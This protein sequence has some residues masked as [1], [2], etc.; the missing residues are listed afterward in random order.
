[1]LIITT[2]SDEIKAWEMNLIRSYL[3]K[4]KMEIG[5]YK[6][7]SRWDGT[8]ANLI[9]CLGEKALKR[10]SSEN[11]EDVKNTVLLASVSEFSG[12]ILSTFGFDRVAVD[13][14]LNHAVMMA[15]I[16]AKNNC[17]YPE[18][19]LPR[20]NIWEPTFQN[21]FAFMESIKDSVCFDL[22]TTISS[23][24]HITH[25]GLATSPLDS[26]SIPLYSGTH[27]RFNE[28]EELAL[29]Q[30]FSEILENENITKINHNLC[31]D[32]SVMLKH[33]VVTKGK[34]FDTMFAMHTCYADLAK[35]DKKKG[36][37][38]KSGKKDLGFCCAL[39]CDVP[40]W[41][42]TS[43][44]NMTYYNALDCCN[45]YALYLSLQRELISLGAE[46]TFLKKCSE[47]E[48][49]IYLSMRGIKVDKTRCKEIETYL[50]GVTDKI[51]L[52]IN[53]EL[54]THYGITEA[55][56]LKS[57]KQ[58][59]NL[60]Y[61]I[62]KL[63]VQ[64]KRPT[65]K[66]KTDAPAITTEAKALERL[67]RQTGN[68]ILNSI[69]DYQK[70]KTLLHFCSMNLS[71]TLRAHTSFN[72]VG[73]AYGRWSSSKNIVMQYGTGNLQ[74]IPKRGVGL[75]IREMYVATEPDKYIVEADFSQAEA[76][77]VA[78]LIGDDVLIDAFSKKQDI[79]KLTASRMFGLAL[80][81]VTSNQRERG[82][83]I[84]HATNYSLG[85]AGLADQLKCSVSEAREHLEEFHSICPQLKRWHLR[86]QD[87]L[88]RTRKLTTPL[89]RTH[90]F[91]GRVGDPQQCAD[92][93]RSAYSFIPQSTIGELL[94]MSLV[95]F[96]HRYGH[97][98]DLLLQLHDAIYIDNVSGDRLQ[99]CKAKLLE[100][101]THELIIGRRECVIGVDFKFGKSWGKMEKL[102]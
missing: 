49:S 53:T 38:E 99:D 83:I 37:L 65:K 74:Q 18:L 7:M 56:N 6:V 92:T 88:V 44:K 30:K 8:P 71:E 33:G 101:M 34:L 62:L 16:K 93:Y 24:S 90:R 89:G 13:W 95:L 50:K 78:Y 73:T 81:D 63:P 32:I 100:C 27:H 51:S 47:I 12:K 41:K 36:E 42:H 5:T 84:R 1:M 77:I 11:F 61:S 87:E 55:I 75:L 15:F 91:L 79:H 26:I 70:H 25:I 17:S 39:F 22:E 3:S 45:T 40:A 80:E 4:L 46:E 19:I 10:F 66:S 102:Q 94:N 31:F 67:Y 97:E 20:Y 85:A 52:S 14:S 59:G 98:Y 72:A 21:C 68:E 29:W 86:I 9:L 96:Y 28:S 69:L 23:P 76:V 2:E 60:L 43:G 57:P 35:A 82:K 64:Y 54:L 48:P 58:L